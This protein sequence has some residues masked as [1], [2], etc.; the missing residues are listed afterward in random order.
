MLNPSKHS[1][2]HELILSQYNL[3]KYYI[4]IIPSDIY[5]NCYQQF[6][7]IK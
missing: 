1:H 4:E 5:S 2:F 3:F 6:P 7:H